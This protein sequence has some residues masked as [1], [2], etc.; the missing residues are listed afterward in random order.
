MIKLNA[1]FS[2]KVGRPIHREVLLDI[3]RMRLITA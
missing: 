1:G 2:L 3:P